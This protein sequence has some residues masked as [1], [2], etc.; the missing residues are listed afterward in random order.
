MADNITLPGAASVAATD[1][2]AGVHFQRIKLIHGA[3]GVNAGDVATGNP[4]PV[5]L[6][7]TD[8]QLRAAVVNVNQVSRTVTNTGYAASFRTVGA[9]AL[10]QNI[11]SIENAAGSTVKVAVTSIVVQMD[12]TAVLVAVMPLTKVS[13]PTALPT[14]GTEL[15]KARRRT[16]QTASASVIVRGATASDGGAATAI[17]ATA[18][19]S[20]RADYN[21]RLHTAVGQVLGNV[22]EMMPNYGDDKP[23]V[24]EA[25]EALLVHVDAAATTSN[26]ATNHW[27]VDIAWEE[28]TE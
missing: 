14:G 15:G 17:T 22:L 19:P 10:L 20:I 21:M 11:A 9:A 4:L 24:L 27:Q 26:P 18:G 6:G 25:G 5:T 12:A 23:L 16:T 7:L 1:D 8:A 3:D 13:R 28:F 2:I